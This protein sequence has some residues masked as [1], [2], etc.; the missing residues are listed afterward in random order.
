MLPKLSNL[1]ASELA[2][3]GLWAFAFAGVAVLVGLGKVN[4]SMLEGL[5]FGLMGSITLRGK[6]NAE[7]STG[8]N[9][10]PR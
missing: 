9:A 2:Q 7:P 5:L 1:S 3:F 6:N 8:T 4:S 10:E